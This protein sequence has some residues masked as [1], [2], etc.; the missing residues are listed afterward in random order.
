MTKKKIQK[1]IRALKICSEAKLCNQKCPYYEE[2]DCSLNEDTLE[3]IKCL[4]ERNEKL[5]T[6]VQK[7]Q[8]KVEDLKFEC[9]GWHY[10]AAWLDWAKAP[11]EERDD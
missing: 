1:V 3:V 7:L 5:Q 11:A 8:K 9:G 2:A 4:Q 6:K 10:D